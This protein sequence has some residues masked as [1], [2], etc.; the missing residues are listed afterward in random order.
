METEAATTPHWTV[1][2]IGATLTAHVER[3]SIMYKKVDEVYEAVIT[4]NGKPSLKAQVSR[5]SDWI[6]NVNRLGWIFISAIIGQFVVSSCAFVTMIVI[7]LGN[8][9]ILAP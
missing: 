1:D 8:A 2:K 3:E 9:G 6:G 5:H 4:G 7:L